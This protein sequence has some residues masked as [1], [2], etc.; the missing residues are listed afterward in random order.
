MSEPVS[1]TRETIGDRSDEQPMEQE[2]LFEAP[3]SPEVLRRSLPG[4]FFLSLLGGVLVSPLVGGLPILIAVALF[5]FYRGL[6][7]RPRVCGAMDADSLRLG[8]EQTI[9][10]RDIR[11]ATIHEFH[12]GARPQRLARLKLGVYKTGE[13]RRAWQADRPMPTGWRGMRIVDPETLLV[14]LNGFTDGG[15][16]LVSNLQKC[17][18]LL[19]SHDP[20]APRLPAPRKSTEHH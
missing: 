6:C 14:D 13:L 17:P 1:A 8:R 18:G 16:R 12:D 19:V 4:F 5:Y 15:A 2:A 9:D 11:A 7:Q 3:P 20:H 10:W